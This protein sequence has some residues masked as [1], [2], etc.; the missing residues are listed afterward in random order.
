M[1]KFD[2]SDKEVTI[3]LYKEITLLRKIIN[4]KP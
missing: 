1:K 3:I 2:I 4:N